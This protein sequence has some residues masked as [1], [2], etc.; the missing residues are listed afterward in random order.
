M[1]WEALNG[2]LGTATIVTGR[3]ARYRH[4]WMNR[5]IMGN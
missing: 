3:K 1:E 2:V 4:R 5:R